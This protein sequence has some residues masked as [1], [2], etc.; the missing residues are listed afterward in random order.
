MHL[1]AG[2]I[3]CVLHGEMPGQ[4]FALASAHLAQC[5]QCRIAVASARREEVELFALLGRIDDPQRQVN[6]NVVRATALRRRPAPGMRWAAGIVLAVGMAG[7]AYAI[8]SSPVRAWFDRL[9]EASPR[10]VA[11]RALPQA[12]TPEDSDFAGVSVSPGAS[13]R[14]I[15]SSAQSSGE[16]RIALADIAD[17]QVRSPAGAVRFA[18]G[19]GRL[20]IDNAGARASYEIVIP[21]AA[22][23]VQIQVAGVRVWRREAGRVVSDYASGP[24]GVVRIPMI[25]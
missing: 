4:A 12:S 19:D 8:P 2:Q 7:V 20:L 1:D 24:D 25:R 5:E 15:F 17:I 23:S 16:L 18:A 21:R 13:A 22:P 6:I 10:T 3:Q 11:P 9:L 14:V